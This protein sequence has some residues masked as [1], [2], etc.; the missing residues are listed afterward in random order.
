MAQIASYTTYVYSNINRKQ[1]CCADAVLAGER[2]RLLRIL[3]HPVTEALVVMTTDVQRSRRVAV[4]A[5][6]MIA[7][8]CTT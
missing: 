1:Y 7:P 4:G 6:K 2:G 8:L 5:A 3:F